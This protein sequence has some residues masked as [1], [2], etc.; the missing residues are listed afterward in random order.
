MIIKI[1]YVGLLNIFLYIHKL[2][3]HEDTEIIICQENMFI[4]INVH[5]KEVYIKQNI[6][7]K[8]CTKI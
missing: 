8:F 3:Y 7:V 2:E 5:K 1:Y 6:A 4:I